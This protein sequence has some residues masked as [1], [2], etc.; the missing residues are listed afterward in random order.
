MI[1]DKLK[2]KLQKLLALAERGVGGEKTN[3]QAMLDAMLEKHNLTMADLS[4]E[5]KTERR[6]EYKNASEELLLAQIIRRVLNDDVVYVIRELKVV[7]QELTQY[8]YV[9]VR[10]LVEFHLPQFRKEQSE[11]RKRQN[12]ERKLMEE[13][14]VNKHRLF[15][16]ETEEEPPQLSPERL[17]ELLEAMSKLEDVEYQK[18]LS[19]SNY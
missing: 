9:M 19:E 6:F 14:Y 5:K 8:E 4:S 13:A 18:K 16:L 15:R 11:L 7:L 2:E 3:A 12:K 10:E 17:A 1:N